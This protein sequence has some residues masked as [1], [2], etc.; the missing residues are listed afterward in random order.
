M[1][2]RGFL[3]VDCG[4]Q[5]TKLLSRDAE[6]GSELALGRAGHELQPPRRHAPAGSAAV[7]G[8]P[9]LYWCEAL[10][11][12]ARRRGR[13]DRGLRPAARA[14]RARSGRRAVP[15]GPSVTT[16]ARPTGMPFTDRC[17]DA[18]PVDASK[19]SDE[20]IGGGLA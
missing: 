8:R 11:N 19:R 15:L 18:Q 17:R 5:S 16:K 20:L 1:A 10:E 13:G 4:S 2:R 14:D 9:R 7:D 6:P 3:R 12:G